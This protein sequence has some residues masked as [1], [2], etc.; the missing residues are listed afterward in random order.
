MTPRVI[1]LLVQNNPTRRLRT[2]KQDEPTKAAAQPPAR[3][4]CAFSQV[5]GLVQLSVWERGKKKKKKAVN[6]TSV[7]LTESELQTM[8]PIR[9][10]QTREDTEK[11]LHCFN[12]K[13]KTVIRAIKAHAGARLLSAVF[14]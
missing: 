2:L 14:I 11:I 4:K 1:W 12:T 5:E 3:A 9:M 10:C 13:N 7:T 8:L 6:A